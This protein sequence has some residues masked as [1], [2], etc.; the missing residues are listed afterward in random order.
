MSEIL[1]GSQMNAANSAGRIR[2]A[3]RA[4]FRNEQLLELVF[5]AQKQGAS[6]EAPML[7]ISLAIQVIGAAGASAERLHDQYAEAVAP[8]PSRL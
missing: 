2:S 8:T 1:K 5:Q 3:A 6:E 4:V 7:S